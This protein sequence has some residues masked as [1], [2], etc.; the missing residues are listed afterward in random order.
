MVLP[1]SAWTEK[2]G[3]YVN[4]EGRAQMTEK[5]AFAPGEAKDDWAVLRALSAHAGQTLPYD[6]LAALRAALYTA[7]PGLARLDTREPAAV[8]GVEALAAIKGTVT[9]K[10]FDSVISDYYLTNPI[11]RA[12]AVMAELSVLKANAGGRKQAAE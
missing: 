9:A 7:V 3:T 12:S 10:P 8:A 5:A 1:G 4:T 6:N 11:A 2:S